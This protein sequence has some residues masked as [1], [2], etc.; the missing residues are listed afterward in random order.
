MLVR[1]YIKRSGPTYLKQYFV[2][3]ISAYVPAVHSERA[4]QGDVVVEPGT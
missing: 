2:P 1:C 4:I 3:H